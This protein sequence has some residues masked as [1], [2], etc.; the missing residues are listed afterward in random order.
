MRLPSYALPDHNLARKEKGAL[1][2]GAPDKYRPGLSDK[3]A[4]VSS[5]RPDRF[6]PHYNIFILILQVFYLH[7]ASCGQKTYK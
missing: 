7:K 2:C 1:F 5:F 6:T 4:M 3:R